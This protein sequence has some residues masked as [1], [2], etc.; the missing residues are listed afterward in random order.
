V[1]NGWLLLMIFSA[2]NHPVLQVKNLNSDN[3]MVIAPQVKASFNT[4]L[5]TDTVLFSAKSRSKVTVEE[6]KETRELHTIIATSMTGLVVGA[7][8]GSFLPIIGTLAG[9]IVLGTL[10]LIVG[11]MINSRREK[12]LKKNIQKT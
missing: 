3:R 5:A 7:V 8:L 9:S 10:G 11:A 6:E 1:I 4:L 2:V 12:K